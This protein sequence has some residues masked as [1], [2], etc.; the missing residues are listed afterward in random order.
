M[1]PTLSE[2]LIVWNL[3]ETTCQGVSRKAIRTLQKMTEGLQCGDDSGLVNVWEEICVQVQ[4]EVLILWDAYDATVVQ[5]LSEELTKLQV[6]ER[7]AI[8]LQTPE[9]QHWE[10]EAEGSRSG[11]PVAEDD[12]LKY[13]SNKYVYSAASGWSNRRIRQYVELSSGTD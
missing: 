7:E 8:W 3:A 9:G 1:T 10:P 12:I 5:V 6:Y 11:Y 2:S 4:G 13:L